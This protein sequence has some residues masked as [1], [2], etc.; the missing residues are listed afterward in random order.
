MHKEKGLLA[1]FD[2]PES[3]AR[4]AEKVRD[5]KIEYFDAFTP[6]PVHGLE[7]SMGLKRSW[8]PWGTLFF[9]L[10]GCA[11]LYL[12]QVWTSA[13]NYPINIGGKPLISWPAF[14][15]VTFEGMVLI[16]GIMTVMMLLAVCR[17]PNITKPALDLRFTDDHFGLLVEKMDP[18]YN[19]EALQQIFRDCHAKEVKTLS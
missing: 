14:I 12:F 8:I 15:P 11:L 10:S 9:G 16:G 13:I 1:I 2:N 19:E 7:H 5:M 3:L 6:F 17:I 18:N 4:A